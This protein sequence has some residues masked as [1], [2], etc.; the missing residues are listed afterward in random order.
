MKFGVDCRRERT[1]ADLAVMA[2]QIASLLPVCFILAASG[3]PAAITRRGLLAAMFGLGCSAIPR[4]EAFALSALYRATTSE[5]VFSLLLPAIALLFGIVMKKWLHS[6]VPRARKT[7]LVYA[8]WIA[9]DLLL[10]LIPVHGSVAFGWPT[11]IAAFVIRAACLALILLD[12]RA[13]KM[14]RKLEESA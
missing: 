10:R 11:A 12:L 6:E 8:A 4:A 2:F 9:L 13:Y 3:Y 7:R 5:I 1:G 14:K